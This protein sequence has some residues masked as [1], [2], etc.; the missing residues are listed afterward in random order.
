[1]SRSLDSFERTTVKT[2]A[3]T[4]YTDEAGDNANA[5]ARL[6]HLALFGRGTFSTFGSPVA[7]LPRRRPC[8][9]QRVSELAI[10]RD[11]PLPPVLR[12]ARLPPAACLTWPA[13][14][15]PRATR[16]ASEAACIRGCSAKASR[17]Q[18]KYPITEIGTEGTYKRASST[19][20][21]FRNFRTGLV[22]FVC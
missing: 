11:G 15:G 19:L 2:V 10:F 21:A 14:L 6:G 20:N 7:P 22:R 16:P 9:H 3:A 17:I 12:P 13:L 1:M 8:G 4:P 5:T 18:P